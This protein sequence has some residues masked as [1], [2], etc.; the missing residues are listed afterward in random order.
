MRGV[1]VIVMIQCHTF[2]SLTRLN[3]R[4]GSAYVLSQFVGGMAAPLFLFMAGMTS[5]FQMEGLE[6]REPNPLRRWRQALHRA[7]YILA[8]AFAF[9]LT[10]WM[11]SIPGGN[12]HEVF[13]V[14]IL[15]W[16]RP[17]WRISTGRARRACCANT[18]CQ[19]RGAG[20]F[21]S[22]RARRTWASGWRW[23]RW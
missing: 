23:A 1:A 7:G 4:D 11:G 3:L 15:N 22:S 12:W 8:I 19:Y 16:F 13:K 14:D 17:F 18:W 21:R 2:N 10:N 20:I 6:R 5:A 9:R